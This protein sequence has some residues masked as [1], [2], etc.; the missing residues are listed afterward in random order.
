[1]LSLAQVFMLR[2][3]RRALAAARARSADCSSRGRSSARSAR[4]RSD[5]I[6]IVRLRQPE[7]SASRITDIFLYL[8]HARAHDKIN[9]ALRCRARAGFSRRSRENPV[10]KPHDVWFRPCIAGQDKYGCKA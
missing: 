5:P 4:L 6:N 2:W 10:A 7:S 9:I 3:I 1:M 8:G